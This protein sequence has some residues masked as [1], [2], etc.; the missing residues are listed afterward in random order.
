M[1][2]SVSAHCFFC[3]NLVGAEGCSLCG[4]VRNARDERRVRAP[5][6]RCG[7][8]ARLVPFGVGEAA[9]QACP[10]CKGMF[11]SAVD[12]DTLL[13]VFGRETLPDILVPDAEGPSVYGPYRSAP[14]SKN[15]VQ[16]DLDADVRCPTCQ[17]AMERLEFAAMTHVVIDVCATHGVWLDAGE[18]ERIIETVHPHRPQPKPVVTAPPDVA[19]GPTP[20]PRPEP[21]REPSTTTPE[22]ATFVPP[23]VEWKDAF[24]PARHVPQ[25]RQA[26]QPWTAQ[27][28]RALGHLLNMIMPRKSPS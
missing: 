19:Y 21:A 18:L 7:S 22:R 14:S 16:V 1:I 8:E 5:C 2:W 20:E 10:R 4:T 24:P 23:V 9:L 28:G 15:A 11:V 26:S 6:P 13:D 17:G 25:E 3:G 27:L 12:W